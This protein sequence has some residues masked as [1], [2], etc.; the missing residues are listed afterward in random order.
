MRCDGKPLEIRRIPYEIGQDTREILLEIGFG[1]GD[2]DTFI[3]EGVVA[4]PN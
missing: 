2:I 3:A 4:G 1:S